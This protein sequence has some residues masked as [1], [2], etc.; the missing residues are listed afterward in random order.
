MAA[1]VTQEQIE[2]FQVDGAILVKG[3]FDEKW[4]SM[5]QAAIKNTME[6]PS[7]FSEM[8]RPVANQG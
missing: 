1:L 6:N 7:Q 3:V 8:L 2:Q 5:A 4:L